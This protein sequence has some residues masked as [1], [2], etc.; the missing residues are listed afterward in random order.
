M[1]A[2]AAWVFGGWLLLAGASASAQDTRDVR[3]FSEGVQ[4]YGR[5]H[6]PKG[7]TADA[8]LPAVVLAPAWMQTASSIEK[9]AAL[10][11][12]RGLVAMAI[13]Y[14][15]WGQS[16]GYV[17]LAEPLRHDDRLRF[18]QHTAKVRIRRKR[19]IPGDQV[20]DIRNA[21]AFL[22][23]EPGV[24]RARVGVWGTDMAGGH[25]VVAAATDARIRAGVAQ[26]PIIEGRDVSRKA[27]LLPS[28]LHA[29]EVRLAR[30][31]GSASAMQSPAG[32]PSPETALALAGYHPFW[33]AEQVPPTTAVLFIVAESDTR[34]DNES[35]AVAASK[36]MKGPTGVTVI[37]GATHAVSTGKA[38]DAAA[39]A[40]ASWFLKYL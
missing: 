18:A 20:L 6:L 17:Y 40:A 37:P 26:V 10:F 3:F 29:A 22:Q 23:G 27:A 16:G 19:L 12:S 11:A 13:D 33:Y 38:F 8:K 4:C 5:L 7:F 30:T 15:G 28:P 9:Y 24:D 36:V 31:G 14:R 39:D 35:H 34:V 32:A 21:V 2:L 1:R 25:V